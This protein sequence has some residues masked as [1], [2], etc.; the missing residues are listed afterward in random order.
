MLMPVYVSQDFGHHD[1]HQH[2]AFHQWPNLQSYFLQIFLEWFEHSLWADLIHKLLTLQCLSCSTQR[3]LNLCDFGSQ[4]CSVKYLIESENIINLNRF[5]VVDNFIFNI[6]NDLMC[7][8]IYWDGVGRLSENKAILSPVLS[9]WDDYS[10]QPVQIQG[11]A[12]DLHL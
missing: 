3:C 8:Q 9:L 6:S 5:C 1:F 12:Q 2:L 11:P 4:Q 7:L 10:V